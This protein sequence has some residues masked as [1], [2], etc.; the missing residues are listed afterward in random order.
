MRWRR[1]LLVTFALGYWTG[2]AVALGFSFL[3]GALRCLDICEDGGA[4]RWQLR[5]DAPQWR[6]IQG[7]AVAAFVAAVAVFAVSGRRRRALV[8][9][10][11]L[12]LAVPLS[13]LVVSGGSI[14]DT[15]WGDAWPLVL[16]AAGGELAAAA[17]VALSSPDE[18][19]PSSP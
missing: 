17:G 10:V 4:V 14:W 8:F 18:R 16:A 3:I 5:W 15:N 11:H 6:V 13:V 9:G 7:L 1:P 2:M 19:P 12:A